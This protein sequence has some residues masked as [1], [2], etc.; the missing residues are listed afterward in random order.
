MDPVPEDGLHV[1]MTRVGSTE[2]VSISQVRR[3]LDLADQLPQESFRVAAHPLAGSRGAVRFTLTPWSSL[4]SLHAALS[5]VGRQVGA[6]GGSPTTA[7]RPHL[8]VQYNNRD[9]VAGPVIESV[10]R[11][12]TLAPVSLEITSV[13]LVELRRVNGASPAYRWRVVGTA[14]LRSS[15]GVS[16]AQP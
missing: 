4:V 14:P 16:A 13:D 11:L 5:E 10:A 15:T 1:T 2:D 3:L 12:R 8:G 7:F 6:P 9:R